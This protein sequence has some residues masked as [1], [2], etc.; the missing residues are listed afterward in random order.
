MKLLLLVQKTVVEAPQLRTVRLDDEIEALRI[1]QR[2]SLLSRL[3][4]LDLDVGQ[5]GR[6]PSK[7]GSI[8]G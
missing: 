1:A 5:H 6:F 8:R 7:A 2:P 4:G 3:G